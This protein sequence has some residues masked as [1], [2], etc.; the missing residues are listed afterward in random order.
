MRA[1]SR[2]NLTITLLRRQSLGEDRLLGLGP[3][4]IDPMPTPPAR[5][6]DRVD[7]VHAGPQVRGAELLGYIFDQP[8]VL[9]PM[10]VGSTVTG[11]AADETTCADD[12]RGDNTPIDPPPAP[13]P[14]RLPEPDDRGGGNL[15][16]I[17]A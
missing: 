8:G 14:N 11:P 13:P 9:Y 2:A 17:Y 15:I 5:D 16:S 12:R 1:A 3:Q 7:L 6:R 4:P 10:P